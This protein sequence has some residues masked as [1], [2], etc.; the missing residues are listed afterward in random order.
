MVRQYLAWS[1]VF[2][3]WS[4]LCRCICVEIC[5]PRHTEVRR[6]RRNSP[7]T[8]PFPLATWL[9]ARREGSE[10]SDDHPGTCVGPEKC[11]LRRHPVASVSSPAIWETVAGRQKTAAFASPVLTAS[12][13]WAISCSYVRSCWGNP[14]RAASMR[15]DRRGRSPLLLPS[16]AAWRASSRAR[17]RERAHIRHLGE[18]S[19]P[20]G[21]RGP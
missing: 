1:G 15:L 12:R 18:R 13:A 3:A 9:S 8:Q 2:L 11:R 4:G 21:R 5:C 6:A 17:H 10:V 14:A 16:P 19:W 20:L 7:T